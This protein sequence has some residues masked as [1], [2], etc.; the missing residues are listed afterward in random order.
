M[1]WTQ[2][3]GRA[4]RWGC[5]LGFALCYALNRYLKFAYGQPCIEGQPVEA[6]TC[7][8]RAIAEFANCVTLIGVTCLILALVISSLHHRQRRRQQ[9]REIALRDTTPD[10]I[11]V[12]LTRRVQDA[13]PR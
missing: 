6:L 12:S 7:G 11:K 8:P 3:L 4:I 13:D 2:G 9:A 10:R 5:W 1:D